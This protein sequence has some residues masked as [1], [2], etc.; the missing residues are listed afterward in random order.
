MVE[1]HTSVGLAELAD[2]ADSDEVLRHAD[3]ARNAPASSAS[4]AWSGTTRMS[5]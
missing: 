4:T 3:L 1:L 2:G 5:R